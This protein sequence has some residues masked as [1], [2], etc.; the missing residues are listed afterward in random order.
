MGSTRKSHRMQARKR[1]QAVRR[2]GA[3]AGGVRGSGPGRKAEELLALGQLAGAARLA[4]EVLRSDPDDAEAQQVYAAALQAIAARH[5]TAEAG[6][7]R[8]RRAGGCS[9]R[10]T[11]PETHQLATFADRSVLYRLDRSVRAWL[12][13]S[14]FEVVEEN[15][16]DWLGRATLEPDSTAPDPA[17]TRMA[18]EHALFAG[19]D[20]GEP[21]LALFADHAG[22]TPRLAVAARSWLDHAHYGLWQVV[23]P[24]PRPGVWLT[25]LVSA[26]SHYVQLSPDQAEALLPWSVL[27]G[28]LVPIEGV[29]RTTG[30]FARLAPDEGDTFCGAVGWLGQALGLLPPGRRSPLGPPGPESRFGVLVG[31]REALAPGA[32]RAL[33]TVLGWMLPAMLATLAWARRQ[34]VRMAA[35]DDEPLCLITATGRPIP[36]PMEDGAR[37]AWAASWVD[38][39]L[40]VL[41]G[42]TPR[43]A[44]ADELRWIDVEALLRTLEHDAALS[45]EG[46]EWVDRLRQLLDI[47]AMARAAVDRRRTRGA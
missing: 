17:A 22:V 18:L 35:T 10:P 47:G 31:Q 36:Q 9:D 37:R 20:D 38:R 19:E 13:G 29:W 42:L 28:P 2:A 1:A 7:P 46:G 15:V 11:G 3:G 14:L 4:N 33:S 43:Q 39:A 45:G 16:G 44:A 23:D 27:A 8:A 5:D 24:R 34:P 40:P 32:A 26:T 12:D 25:D 21:V 6:G 41:G 30:G